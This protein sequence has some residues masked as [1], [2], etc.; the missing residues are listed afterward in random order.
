MTRVLIATRTSVRD[1]EKPVSIDS[2]RVADLRGRLEAAQSNAGVLFID[3][4]A[5]AEI[6]NELGKQIAQESPDIIAVDGWQGASW[7]PDVDVP[8]MIDLRAMQLPSGDTSDEIR[9]EMIEDIPARIRALSKADFFIV[10]DESQRLYL[11][12]WLIFAGVDPYDLP[13]TIM[14]VGTSPNTEEFDEFVRSPSKRTIGSNTIIKMFADR[15]ELLELNSKLLLEKRDLLVRV[16]GAEERAQ[17]AELSLRKVR[18]DLLEKREQIVDLRETTQKELQFVQTKLRTEIAKLQDSGRLDMKRMQEQHADA[19]RRLEEEVKKLRS[20]NLR[21]REETDGQ[22]ADSRG[23]A[24]GSREEML[25]LKESHEGALANMRDE[26]MDSQRRRNEFEQIAGRVPQLEVDLAESRTRAS[27]LDAEMD[28]LTQEFTA[29]SNEIQ[30]ELDA[31]ENEMDAKERMLVGLRDSLAERDTQLHTLEVALIEKDAQAIAAKAD[32]E[33]AWG[34]VRSFKEKLPFRIFKRF[35][36]FVARW[37]NKPRIYKLM[38]KN[39]KAMSPSKAPPAHTNGSN[40]HGGSAREPAPSGAD[41]KE[42]GGTRQSAE[43]NPTWRGQILIPYLEGV[44]SGADT[45]AEGYLTA[46]LGASG[47][48]GCCIDLRGFY[49][50]GAL[51]THPGRESTD[52]TAV[53]LAPLVER[54]AKDVARC[55]PSV[56]A[57]IPRKLTIEAILSFVRRIRAEGCK[58]PALLIGRELRDRKFS[59]NVLENLHG[60]A[61][62][63]IAPLHNPMEQ[64]LAIQGIIEKMNEGSEVNL[65]ELGVISLNVRERAELAIETLPWAPPVP[66]Y[67]HSQHDPLPPAETTGGPLYAIAGFGVAP[68]RP[69]NEDD[70]PVHF[71]QRPAREVFDELKR[72]FYRKMHTHVEFRDVSINMDSALLRELAG[73]LESWKDGPTFHARAVYRVELDD[74]S[75]EALAK[76]RFK[77]LTF[78]VER[79]DGVTYSGLLPV[80]DEIVER[81]KKS[82]AKFG[83]EVR[84][85]LARLSPLEVESG[86]S[87]LFFQCPAW[88]IDHPPL[89]ISYLS[90]ALRAVGRIG[91]ICDI[92]AQLYAIASDKLSLYWDTNYHNSWK[93]RNNIEN[94]VRLTDF[95][96]ERV[97]DCIEHSSVRRFGFTINTANVLYSLEVASRI[98]RRMPESK[99]IFGGPQ[100]LHLQ[101]PHHLYEGTTEQG[102]KVPGGVIDAI[103]VGEGEN[104]IVDWMDALDSNS[105][106]P[107]PG[108]MKVFAEP[109]EGS[110]ERAAAEVNRFGFV[111]YF[112][113]PP[114]R[115]WMPKLND[116]PIP[117]LDFRVYA[118]PSYPVMMSRGCPFACNFCSDRTRWGKF[119]FRDAPFVF[120]EIDRGVRE[121]GFHRVV[122]LDSLVNSSVNQLKELISLII[123][124]RLEFEWS[125]NAVIRRQMTPELCRKMKEAGC[126]GLAF[127]TESFSDNVLALMHKHQTKEE[128]TFVLTNVHNA[129]IR[130]TA[131]IIVGYPGETEEDFQES[132]LWVRENHHL[133]D[134]IGLLSDCQVIRDTHLYDLIDE[135]NILFKNQG[136]WE[137]ADRTNTHD[138]RKDR[139]QRMAQLLHEV[140]VF[141]DFNNYSLKDLKKAIEA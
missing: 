17:S 102:Q 90:A 1:I 106:D 48:L 138:I 59:L 92:N 49:G 8:L 132:V 89:G 79:R 12:S 98:R 50:G 3:K 31:L 57:L 6:G 76:A 46:A 77:R 19:I 39:Y 70:V 91:Q 93:N 2:R 119:R 71:F 130:V 68:G 36:K 60:L 16:R 129:G 11:A 126:A 86:T 111:E 62:V 122:F 135:R 108:V 139:L 100:M 64:N 7:L 109:P 58:A 125:G 28:K 24:I 54:F 61:N 74:A 14:P 101:L 32:A 114:P 105:N 85:D 103:A 84:E 56:I 38:Y 52:E 99:I 95:Y 131:N 113:K 88:G 10:N 33:N 81:I 78:F 83:I 133:I 117:E 40:G 23:Q 37:R 82:C 123:E 51:H 45:L 53:Q 55:A 44:F 13:V 128:I 34:I 120:K 5:G 69:E 66:A 21:I 47:E 121:W 107:V 72:R 65:S 115:D 134:M 118:D 42:D 87:I 94:I 96:L 80:A 4:S 137:L 22:I 127:G 9:R 141:V 20:E 63:F 104:T 97:V 30:T 116:L 136:D 67:F 25:K 112:E 110:A 35:E 18:D 124:N 140:G 43:V 29:L 26:L 15:A 73:L 75:I 27:E 41:S